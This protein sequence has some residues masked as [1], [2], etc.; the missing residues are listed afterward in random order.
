MSSMKDRGVIYLFG[1]IIFVLIA[2]SA[3]A[4]LH[5]RHYR[6]R[7]I[8]IDPDKPIE[9]RISAIEMILREDRFT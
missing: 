9:E 2:L 8:I 4:M 7:R 6:Q 1:A 3:M 5:E